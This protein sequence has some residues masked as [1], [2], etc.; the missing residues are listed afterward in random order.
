MGR[1]NGRPARLVWGVLSV[2]LVMLVL[3]ASHGRPSRAQ[4]HRGADGKTDLPQSGAKASPTEE[5]PVKGIQA[6]L[7]SLQGRMESL[8]A[9]EK[10]LQAQAR[11]MA[12]EIKR[13]EGLLDVDRGLRGKGPRGA[14]IDK[15]T[16]TAGRPD[17]RD[18]M[19]SV[20]GMLAAW[21]QI[22][23]ILAKLDEITTALS[24]P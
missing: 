15:V 8:E 17:A 9:R 20:A 6:Q 24:R 7:R 10:A 3:A 18:A 12:D 14:A 5:G 11:S 13:L 4:D 22:D 2:S 19:V 16:R 1:P 21:R 23:A